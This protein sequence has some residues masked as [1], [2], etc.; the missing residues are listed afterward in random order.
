MGYSNQGYVWHLIAPEDLQF[1]A[2]N[3]LLTYLAAIITP[4]V[5]PMPATRGLHPDDAD[6]MTAEGWMQKSDFNQAGKDLLQAAVHAD[7]AHHHA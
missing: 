5:N 3:N 2:T 7:S 6:S 1:Q 4:W